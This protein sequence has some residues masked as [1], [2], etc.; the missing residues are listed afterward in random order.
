MEITVRPIRGQKTYLR[1]ATEECFKDFPI[2]YK[3]I[4]KPHD[5]ES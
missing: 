4:T 5:Q 1:Q 2:L 3:S